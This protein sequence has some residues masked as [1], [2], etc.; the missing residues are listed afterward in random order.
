M[1]KINP[2]CLD[3]L[4]QLSGGLPDASD[5]PGYC[6]SGSD[7]SVGDGAVTEVNLSGS[8]NA[9]RALLTTSAQDL[10]GRKVILYLNYS[11]SQGMS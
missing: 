11:S 6:W 4:S 7:L 1:L 10:V 2:N 5:V 9:S 8:I 3:Y